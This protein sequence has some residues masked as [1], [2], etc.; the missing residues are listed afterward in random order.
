[1]APPM[2]PLSY[3]LQRMKNQSNWNCSTANTGSISYGHIHPV[4]SST[5]LRISSLIFHV[6][7]PKHGFAPEFSMLNLDP[8]LIQ[9]LLLVLVSFRAR[10]PPKN[11]IWPPMAIS[12]M[13]NPMISSPFQS[14]LKTRTHIVLPSVVTNTPK[15]CAGDSWFPNSA[16]VLV[17]KPFRNGPLPSSKNGVPLPP[18]PQPRSLSTKLLPSGLKE[19]S[20]LAALMAMLWLPRNLNLDLFWLWRNWR[21]TVRAC[22]NGP[23][24]TAIS[25]IVL[26]VLSCVPKVSI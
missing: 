1:M 25:C 4:D 12:F 24:A 23:S 19:S 20:T 11:G 15:S 10:V 3:W 13:V 16:I 22:S 26:R 8:T 6:S 2:S 21:S 5:T 14:R 18:P 17:S 9:P 7:I